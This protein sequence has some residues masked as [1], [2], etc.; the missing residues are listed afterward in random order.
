MKVK[1]YYCCL[2]LFL[3]L[4]NVS[5]GQEVETNANLSQES[6]FPKARIALALEP[7][8]G[9]EVP[10]PYYGGTDGFETVFQL[11]DTSMKGWIERMCAQ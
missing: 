3:T 6:D 9:G 10:D 1:I 4:L 7:M 8:G 11:L 5:C 2:L